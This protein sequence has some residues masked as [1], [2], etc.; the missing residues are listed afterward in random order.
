M[1]YSLDFFCVGAED[2]ELVERDVLVVCVREI[3]N[4]NR[5]VLYVSEAEVRAIWCGFCHFSADHPNPLVALHSHHVSVV[6]DSC[7]TTMAGLVE[8]HGVKM[9]E[10]VGCS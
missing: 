9:F 10:E 6:V 5:N 8:E 7:G 2:F 4:T 1:N 3:E